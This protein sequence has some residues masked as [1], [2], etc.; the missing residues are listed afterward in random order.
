M[1]YFIN[2]SHQHMCSYVYPTIVVMQRI[3][4]KVSSVTNTHNNERIVGRLRFY[5]TRVV[6]KGSRPLVP[7]HLVYFNFNYYALKQT[8]SDHRDLCSECP[9]ISIESWVR[10]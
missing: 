1:A 2:P 7:E 9:K 5:A 10:L 8:K 3:G 6:S 4:I